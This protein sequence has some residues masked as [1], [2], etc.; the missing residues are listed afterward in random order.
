MRRRELLSLLGGAV[1]ARPAAAQT[2]RAAGSPAVIGMMSPFTRADTEPW[3][4]AFRQALRERGWVEGTNIRFE[5]RY[6]DGRNEILPDLVADLIRQKPDVIVVSVNT[7]ARPT[8]A[9][10]KTIPI[11]MAAP[12]DPVAIGLVASLARPGGNV[13]GLSQMA[14]DLAAKRLQLLKEVAPAISRIAVLWD[15]RNPVSSLA[16]Q[17][18]QQPARQLGLA[19]HSVE[20]RDIAELDAALARIV[21]ARDDALLPLPSPIFVVNEARLADFAL[22]HRLPSM[23]HLP[24]FARAGGL[25]SYGPD[26]AELFRRAAAYVDKI[27]K[28][29]N[30][31]ELPVEQAT[32][33]QLVINLKTAQAL[34]LAV[35]QPLLAR[36]DEIVE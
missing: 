28:G 27:L 31:A 30:P 8:A 34:G 11:V 35:P 26:R 10:T 7:D 5:Y 32:K 12:G 9:A 36:A 3:H 15:P 19:L 17:E 24:E 21:V 23:F 29:A 22:K 4:E 16:W 33:F 25:M 20:L 2:G 6:G 13:T 18:M 1:L 14:T